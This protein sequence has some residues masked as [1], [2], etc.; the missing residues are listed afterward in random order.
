MI[1]FMCGHVFAVVC[2]YVCYDDNDLIVG[3]CVAGEIPATLGHL[4]GLTELNLG[5]NKLSG[6]A[7]PFIL[8]TELMHMMLVIVN[9]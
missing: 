4:T 7:P 9:V 2:V 1:V 5:S 8:A 6:E 3:M